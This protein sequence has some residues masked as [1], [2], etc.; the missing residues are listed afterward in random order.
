MLETLYINLSYSHNQI[1]GHMTPAITRISFRLAPDGIR[2][3]RR[4][5]ALFPVG[6]ERQGWTL[7]AALPFF[8]HYQECQS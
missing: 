4:S 6:S 2:R 1:F 5:G 3:V 8:P 7:F